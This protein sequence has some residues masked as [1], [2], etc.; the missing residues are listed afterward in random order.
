PRAEMFK[1]IEQV[2][3]KSKLYNIWHMWKKIKT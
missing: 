3:S 1:G 2:F